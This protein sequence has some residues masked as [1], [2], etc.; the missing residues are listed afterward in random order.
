MKST[1][2]ALLMILTI[3]LGWAQPSGRPSGAPPQGTPPQREAVVVDTLLGIINKVETVSSQMSG[4]DMTELVLVNGAKVVLAPPSWL[5]QRKLT[6]KAGDK[7]LVRGFESKMEGWFAA[8]SITV[9]DQ[10]LKLRE[11][12]GRPLWMEQRGPQGGPQDG[13]PPSRH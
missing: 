2:A 1:M 11:E 3:G 9:G 7:V 10:T 6:F 5:K 8:I 12:D 13:M 4:E